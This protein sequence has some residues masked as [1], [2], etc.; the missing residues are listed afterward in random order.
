MPPRTRR[1]TEQYA[2]GDQVVLLHAD[3][4][5]EVGQVVCLAPPGVW[6]QPRSG[7]TRWFVTN[8]H[9]LRSTAPE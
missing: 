3:G 2:V 5:S 1:I 4:R 7:G 6:F 8:P 9:R